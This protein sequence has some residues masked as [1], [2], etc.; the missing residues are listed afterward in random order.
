MQYNITPDFGTPLALGETFEIAGKM[1]SRDL[2]RYGV[3]AE[4]GVELNTNGFISSA[5]EV[6]R[7][8][9]T[10]S[11]GG[12]VSFTITGAVTQRLIDLASQRGFQAYISFMLADDPDFSSGAS[13]CPQA[14][15][16]LSVLKSRRAPLVSSVIVGD[17]TGAMAYF[18]GAVESKSRLYM[19]VFVNYD[20]LD[21]T[22]TL[23]SAEVTIGEKQFLFDGRDVTDRRLVIGVPDFSGNF[24]T[25]HIRV[26][27]SKGNSGDFYG[28]AIKIYPY[29][30]PRLE[31][32]PDADLV[33]RYELTTGDDGA[34]YMQ[35]SD[36]GTYLQANFSADVCSIGGKNA[37]KLQRAY[38]EYGWGYSGTI[39]VRSGADGEA[40]TVEGGAD[41]F[42]RS[43]VFAAERRY[44]VQLVLK[45]YF[46]TSVIS[47]DV[48]K[49]GGY[50]S[51]ERYGVAAG[52][53]STGTEDAPKFES[54]YPVYA[55]GGIE[56]VN[57]YTGGEV[58]TG[59]RWLDGKNIYRNVIPVLIEEGGKTVDAAIVN[60]VDT[61]IRIDGCF[62]DES[63]VI[64]PPSFFLS[65]SNYL[66]TYFAE[67]TLRICS[68][69]A[70]NGYAVLYYTRTRETGEAYKDIV[71]RPAAAMTSNSSQ[72]C[73]V[74]ASSVY[75][76]SYAAYKAFDKTYANQYG[77]ASAY[78]EADEWIQIR[79]DVA[80]RNI[81]VTIINRTFEYVNGPQ[82]GT[83]QG[84][85]DGETWEDI[86]A[87]E[88]RNGDT[89][90]YKSVH[91]CSNSDMAYSY[92]RI[93]CRREGGTMIAIGE[94]YIEGEEDSATSVLGEAV[95]GS[96][97][98][99]S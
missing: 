1:Y 35:L 30:A 99:G 85:N 65:T 61:L 54:V 23:A 47:C 83:I 25:Y 71:I 49:A 26:T 93:N 56:G 3:I 91:E 79:L 46:E 58:K 84:S 76:S 38:A 55:Y 43:M 36:S 28:G 62:A 16:Q 78:G 8:E 89:S 11:R 27:D 18:G 95:L 81:S 74:T 63:G 4:A 86:A 72:G 6:G 73:E 94:I 69:K 9:K 19:E 21:P 45:D 32:L 50:F 77:W 64:Y 41:I 22:L 7:V 52:M 70:L 90:G 57:N 98:L 53:R 82:S 12:S 75:S 24:S 5:R 31:T 68:T 92:V 88:G 67:D 33:Q 44:S 34:Q 40:F 66:A 59:G 15:Q 48:D 51:I 80:L 13:T 37:W 96:M 14:A 42:P 39:T 60:H 29:Y 87:F 20:P 10:C 97:I 2:K 17:D